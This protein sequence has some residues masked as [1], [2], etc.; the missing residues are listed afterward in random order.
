MGIIG[1]IRAICWQLEP[2]E[3]F[4]GTW[5]SG[6]LDIWGLPAS[7]P[8]VQRDHL[9]GP[10][11]A[12]GFSWSLDTWGPLGSNPGVHWGQILGFIGII[13]WGLLGSNPGVH[14][15]NVLESIGIM[16]WDLSGPGSHSGTHRNQVLGS[17]GT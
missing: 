1:S 3:A 16:R 17:V 13:P 14:W 2:P 15:D 12:R 6:C 9:P 11:S 4:P 7:F 5:I 10:R 8:G